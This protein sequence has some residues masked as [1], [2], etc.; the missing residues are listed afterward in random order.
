VA[1]TAIGAG[2]LPLY[3]IKVRH[4]FPHQMS[5]LMSVLG[6]SALILGIALP[7][8]SDRVGRKRVMIVGNL[9]GMLCPLAAMYYSGPFIVLALLVFAGW[10]PV[11]A[12]PLVFATIPSESVS[13]HSMSTAIGLI[14]AAGTLIGGVAGPTIAGW[15]ADHWGLVAPML[16]LVGCAGAIAAISLGLKETAPGRKSGATSLATAR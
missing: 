16:L 2:F 6:V 9:L 4:F 15:G 1:Y 5:I 7:T 10:A 13:A 11:G 3:Y 12:A 14:L 8:I